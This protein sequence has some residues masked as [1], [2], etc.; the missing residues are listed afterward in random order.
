MASKRASIVLSLVQCGETAWDGEGRLHGST[1]LP[2]SEAGREVVKVAATGLT[3]ARFNTIYHPPDEAATET[4]EWYAQGCGAKTKAVPELADPDLGLL[5]GL[6]EQAFSERFLKRY[7][8]WHDDPLSLSPPEGEDLSD[9]RARIFAMVARLLRRS[10]AD[11]VA[12][13][14][15]SLGL[16]MV[17]CWLADRSPADLWEVL[18]AGRRVERYVLAVEMIKWLEA[19]AKPEFSGS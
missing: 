18:R 15:H 3:S 2:L 11:E 13:V 12:V 17:R 14:L 4:A 1:D 16:G 19:V 9:A 6:G 7:R 10:R 8:Q 5:E